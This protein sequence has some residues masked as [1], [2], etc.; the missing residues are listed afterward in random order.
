MGTGR[1]C[2]WGLGAA[3]V[4]VSWACALSGCGADPAERAA[5]SRPN[6]L[7]V[8]WDTVRADRMSLYGHEIETTPN[9]D[10]WARGARVFEDVVSAA[11][12]TESSHA[13]MFTGLL[14]SQ[15]RTDAAH[16]WLDDDFE[17]VAE[18]L[19]GSGYRTYLWSANPSVSAEENFQQGFDRVEHPWDE[20]FRESARRIVERKVA[21]DRSSELHRRLARGSPGPWAIKAA[22]SLVVDALERWLVESDSSR[23]YF[24][25]LNYMEA[26]RP[27]VPERR[28]RERVMAAEEVELSYGVDRSWTGMW[29]FTTGLRDFSPEEL[30]AMQGTYD[31]AVLELDELFSQLLGSLAAKGDLE[32]TVVIL[33]ADHGELLGENHMLDHQFSLHRALVN[34]PLVIHFPSRFPPGREAR[35]VSNMDLY[36]TILELASAGVSD[37]GPARSAQSLLRPADS[38]ARLSEYTAANTKTLRVLAEKHPDFDVVPYERSLRALYAGDS[39]FVWS[40][41]GR[42]EL[43]DLAVDPGESD[44]RALREPRKVEQMHDR[45]AA[46]MSNLGGSDRE[47]G[48]APMPSKAHREMLESLG[49]GDSGELENDGPSHE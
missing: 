11:N 34:V 46:F 45:L 32:N 26:H 18:A 12:T 39:K 13:S 7:W 9:L 19:E 2:R 43:Y 37:G 1:A 10:L 33:T 8:V 44:D 4:A 48:E 31:A 28:F 14:P 29:E 38:R 5:D 42:H 47:P 36:P 40:S 16:R 15:H 27:L 20:G 35:P 30:R 17:T 3:G 22:G 41:D 21:N 25:V 6:I 23:P 24:A 49:Y